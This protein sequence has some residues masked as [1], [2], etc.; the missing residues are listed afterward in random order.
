M[1]KQRRQ[2]AML[3]RYNNPSSF[4]INKF[5][6][7]AFSSVTAQVGLCQTS[8]ETPKTG[9][10]ESRLLSLSATMNDYI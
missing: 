7:L 1:Q 2:S 5:K 9:F 8:P 3:H 6:L 4:Q 10:L